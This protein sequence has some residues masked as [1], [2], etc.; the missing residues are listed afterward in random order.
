MPRR[1]LLPP[2]LRS[3]R[4]F[5]RAVAAIICFGLTLSVTMS[6]SCDG[7]GGGGSGAG[8]ISRCSASMLRHASPSF[9]IL[10]PEKV[11]PSPSFS[12]PLGLRSLQSF[13]RHL[14]SVP[15][16]FGG[17]IAYSAPGPPSSHTWSSVYAQRA[18][19]S[20]HKHGVR[21]GNGG[22]NG[23]GGETVLYGGLGGGGGLGAVPCVAVKVDWVCQGKRSS[24]P[25]SA[26]NGGAKTDPC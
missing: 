5:G 23:G 25:N 2:P 1:P 9:S 8:A 4:C 10:L 21:G 14:Q 3:W 17:H 7:T 19:L 13:C 24:T 26:S 12:A 6:A 18:G 11:G 22:G 16:V 15:S 20:K